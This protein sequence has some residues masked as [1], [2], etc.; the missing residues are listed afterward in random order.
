MTERGPSGTS[1]DVASHKAGDRQRLADLERRLRDMEDALRLSNGKLR[2]ALD[3]GRLGSWERDLRTGEI[4]GSETFK[5]TLGLPPDAPLKA[6]EFEK[7][8]HPGDM[9]RVNQA[10]VFALKTK[11]DFNVEHRVI[12][13]DGRIGRILVRGG[14]VFEG[15]EPVRL[16]GVVQDVT[17]REK[18]KEEMNSAQRRQE[19]LLNLNDQ[20]RSLE[21]P[22]AIM[23]ATAKSL[24]RFL[25]VDCAGYGEVDEER[26]V[27]LVEREWSEGAIGNEGRA[28]RL[29]D[30]LPTMMAELKQGR[31]IFVED[32]R[33]DPRAVNPEVQA[34]YSTINAR[35]ALAVPLLK[36]QKLTAVLYMHTSQRRAW[37]GDE[38]SL[39]EDVAERTWTAVEKARAERDLR[40]TDARFRLIAESLPALVWILN[41][42]TELLYTN[43]RWVTYSGLPPEEA[44]G[45]SWT[46]AIHPDDM[47]RMNEELVPV[48]TKHTSYTT[49]ARYRSHEGVYRWHLIQGA[50]IHSPTGEFKGWV[51]TSVDIHDLKVT[52]EALRKS[53]EQ[54]RIAL[55]AAK[56]GDWSWDS[57]SN[58]VSPSDHAAEIL[59]AALGSS[60]RPEEIRERIHPAD[61]PNMLN[62]KKRAAEAG[63]PY[64]VQYRIRRFND[65]A[66]IWIATQAQTAKKEDGT[67]VT[68]G[69][70]QD[71]TES[72]QA[73]ERQQLLIRE[74]HHRVK[75]TLATVQAIVGST[76][77]TA[78]SIDEFYQGFV[79]RIVSLARTHNLLTEDLW[80]KAAL[81]DLVQTELG[82]Y[83]DEARNRIVVEGPHVE[84]PSEAAVP[85]GMAIHELTT[86]A[87][88]HGALSTFGGQVEVRWRV[89]P[90]EERPVLHFAWTEH[91]GPKV[92]TP[93]RQGFGS[94]LLQRVLATQLQADVAM[95][96]PEEGLHFTMT[97]TIPGTP[98]IF[99]PDRPGN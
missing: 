48:V 76:A 1:A 10:I 27:I 6:E 99:N 18:A 87:A 88:K 29:Y 37:F 30:F 64:N 70:I 40:E 96:F 57:V 89:E 85:I 73:E 3:I 21:D 11:T 34:A 61:L 33:T 80:Q 77:R 75:N 47:A 95:T 68:S 66:E 65:N 79:G 32:I 69:I 84:L 12:R 24:G 9:D 62:T 72:K 38:L 36:N 67:L 59:G 7:L 49:E 2:M 82:P 81:E 4:T 83:E 91:G 41:P 13:P 46:R 35:A 58:M 16:M 26:G 56:M 31:P 44:L 51:G 39:V 63:Q 28:Y 74:L 50:P 14:A 15:D 97:M 23:E 45:H 55:Q 52:E 71:I 98:P 78:S 19:F 93:T 20:L 53:E 92:S 22:D 8:I 42:Q 86:N 43:E 25:K 90:G 94:R 60:M 5:A 54:L 17:A